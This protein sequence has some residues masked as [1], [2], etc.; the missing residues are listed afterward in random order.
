MKEEGEGEGNKYYFSVAYVILL[1][2]SVYIN[3]LCAQS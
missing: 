2:V 1:S 3:D